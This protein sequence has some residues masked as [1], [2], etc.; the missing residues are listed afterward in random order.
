LALGY[1]VD[2]DLWHAIAADGRSSKRKYRQQRQEQS[3][4]FMSAP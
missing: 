2:R 1:F 3:R 4:D